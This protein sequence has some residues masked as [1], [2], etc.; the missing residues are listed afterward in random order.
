VGENYKKL[1]TCDGTTIWEASDRD[2][3]ASKFWKAYRKHCNLVVLWLSNT[4]NLEKFLYTILLHR[5]CVC[6]SFTLDTCYII[7]HAI[8]VT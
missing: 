1:C 3:V 4:S 6:L 7:L 8:L 2:F 5:Q